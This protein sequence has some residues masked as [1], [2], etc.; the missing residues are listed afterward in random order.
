MAARPRPARRWRSSAPAPTGVK[1]F[2]IEGE[3]GLTPGA[4][5]EDDELGLGTGAGQ[6]L[7]LIDWNDF[8]IDDHPVSSV[9]YGTP[10]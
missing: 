7:L 5:Y 4:N 6:S 2:V 8:G 9:V 1:V 3:G 10:S